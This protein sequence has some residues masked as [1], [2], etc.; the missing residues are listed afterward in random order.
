MEQRECLE[1]LGGQDATLALPS[2]AIPSAISPEIDA[3]WK[4]LLS[5]PHPINDHPRLE[6]LRSDV[7]G[8]SVN[9]EYKAALLKSIDLYD[10]YFIN[11]PIYEHNAGW[12][13]LDALLRATLGDLNEQRLKDNAPSEEAPQYI[14]AAELVEAD[15]L[16]RAIFATPSAGEKW[17]AIRLNIEGRYEALA[18]NI[19]DKYYYRVKYLELEITK[20]QFY[21][22]VGNPKLHYFSTAL[23]LHL[24]LERKGMEL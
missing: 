14:S 7:R 8:L 16:A 20:H 6:L 12:D 4:D 2:L 1:I 21:L 24:D 15:K 17:S 23:S 9:D 11:R 13:D 19:G 3:A 5:Q 10:N 22:V 18:I